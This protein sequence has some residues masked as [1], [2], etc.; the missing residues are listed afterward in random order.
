M[1]DGGLNGA[2][3]NISGTNLEISGFTLSGGNEGRISVRDLYT[4]SIEKLDSINLILA[5]STD[6]LRRWV[7]IMVIREDT[8]VPLLFFHKLLA[9]RP[10]LLGKN[11]NVRGVV[12]SV[13]GPKTYIQD[14]IRDTLSGIVI[15]GK[16]GCLS[17]GVCESFGNF[18][19]L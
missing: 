11:V 13:I 6:T 1:L 8:T 12:S 3:Y 2:S 9:E 19:T 10:F 5:N 14:T 4:T 17:W 15:Y 16:I 7:K 18:S